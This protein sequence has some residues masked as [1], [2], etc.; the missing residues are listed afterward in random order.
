MGLMP[1]VKR[2]LAILV[3]CCTLLVPAVPASAG[4]QLIVFPLLSPKFSSG[5]GMRRH[6]VSRHARHHGGIDLAA[7]EKSHVRAVLDGTVVFSGTYAGY[8]KLITIEHA[9]GR[10]TLYGHLGDV[11]VNLGQ[12]VSAGD[13]IGRVGSTGIATG[14]HLHFE[15]RENGKPVDPMKVFSSFR[16]LPQG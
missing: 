6:P 8:G 11:L 3:L 16:A 5:Y 9:R 14:P 7:P 13:I 1:S 4:G 2:T 15:W 12:R 10:T